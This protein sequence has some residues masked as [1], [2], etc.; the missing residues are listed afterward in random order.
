M[1]LY[2][3]SSARSCCVCSTGTLKRA[4]SPIASIGMWCRQASD[5]AP[6]YSAHSC[7]PKRRPGSTTEETPP[8]GLRSILKLAGKGDAK[9]TLV[10]ARTAV[11]CHRAVLHVREGAPDVPV[12]LFSTTEPWAE[13]ADACERVF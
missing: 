6:A 12:W 10:F 5:P 8:L 7:W 3:H 2:S 13:T 4:R 9:V 11:D 1:R